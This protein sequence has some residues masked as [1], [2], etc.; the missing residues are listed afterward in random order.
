MVDTNPTSNTQNN[1]TQNNNTQNDNT[2]QKNVTGNCVYDKYGRSPDKKTICGVGLPSAGAD[3]GEGYQKCVFE[4]KCPHC[5]N[6]TLRWGWHWEENGE[7][8]FAGEGGN[9]EG[10]FFCY[11]GDGGCDADYSAQG[12]EHIDGSQYNMTILSGPTPSTEEEAQQLV[13]G[14]LPC[15]STSGGTSTTSTSGGT[16]VI[17]TDKSFYGLIK[18]M[19]GAIDGV[20]IIANNM[21]Y[22]L[23]FSDFYKYRDQF[24]DYIPE[25][26]ASD[27]VSDSII[28]HWTTSGLYNAVEV[29]YADGIIK[30]QY[31]ALIEMYGES[32]FYY[33]FPEDD[34]ETAKAKASALLSA[35]VRD[36]SLDLQLNCIY[37]PNIT[38]GS[39]VKL[40]KKLTKVSGQTSV[41]TQQER[42]QKQQPK[43]LRKGVTIENMILTFQE[44]NNGVAK[45][46]QTITTEDGEQ[47]E[48]EVSKKDYE[49]YFVQSLKMR[50]TSDYAPIMSLHLK[51]GPD[52]PEDPL[53]TG[54]GGFGSNATSTSGTALSGN[55]GELVAQWIQGKSTDLEK[56][57]AV[58]NGLK[59]Y[60]ISYKRYCNFK[61]A[62]PDECLAHSKD[63]GLNCGDTAHL[64][65]ECMHQAGLSS[66]YIQLRCDNAHFF[67]VIEI[68][69]QKYYSDLT[70]DE[71][72]GTNRNWNEVWEGNTC[73]SKYSDG[74][75][76]TPNASDC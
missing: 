61:Y 24:E 76:I 14:Q 59:E 67:T 39:W 1:D 15:E 53:V 47:Y 40:P 35:H 51:Y 19:L 46:I 26:Q 21:A 75:D 74:S 50:W 49:L 20:F 8:A 55:I 65:V 63:P 10:H 29:T 31:D 27:I 16:G 11:Q 71:G 13:D 3:T 60:G 41:Q 48:I 7:S 28:R 45:N 25:L 17:I 32:V 6:E 43:M 38:V 23:S 70:A 12:H 22:L 34:E 68:N 42:K 30:Y 56:A 9:A 64:T 57:E 72:Q 62:T 5:G 66:A 37:N 2:Q 33:E 18:Q 36:Y 4:N 44:L 69:G 54:T 52:T 73:G 58:H